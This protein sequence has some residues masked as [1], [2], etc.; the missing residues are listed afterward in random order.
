MSKVQYK[1]DEVSNIDVIVLD[2]YADDIDQATIEGLHFQESI[3]QEHDKELKHDI[4][5]A[6]AKI[7]N[8][9]YGYCEKTGEP[10]EIKRLLTVPTAKYTVEVQTKIE[11]AH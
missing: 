7:K 2:K 9:S 1:R 3:L 4:L 5:D 10:I 8:G 11:K 6:I